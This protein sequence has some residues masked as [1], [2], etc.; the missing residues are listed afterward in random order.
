MRARTHPDN[1]NN[2]SSAADVSLFRHWLSRKRDYCT[3]HASDIITIYAGMLVVI[4][5]LYVD[6][7]FAL[8]HR[9]DGDKQTTNYDIRLAPGALRS[10]CNDSLNDVHLAEKTKPHLR[11]W[12]QLLSFSSQQ[13]TVTEL[14]SSRNVSGLAIGVMRY[15]YANVYWAVMDVYN[16]W[17]ITRFLNHTAS[18]D[19]AIVL[20]DTAPVTSLDS[21][22]QTTFSSVRRVHTLGI[23]TRFESMA[24]LFSRSYSP[25]LDRTLA[26]LPLL[27]EFRRDVLAGNGIVGNYVR[28]CKR[29]SVFFVLRRDYSRYGGNNTGSSRVMSNFV[30]RKI[31]NEHELLTSIHGSFPEFQVRAKQLDEHTMTEQLQFLAHTDVLIGMHGAAMTLSMFMP[32]GGAVIEL[33]PR[34]QRNYNWHMEAIARWSG[35]RYYSWRNRNSSQEDAASGYTTVPPDVV[36]SRVMQAYTDLC[37]GGV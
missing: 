14:T 31:R 34:Y 25:L 20:F 5:N 7:H 13:T 36:V 26:S 24:W 2:V 22:W 16:C 15:E 28:S 19:T 12:L 35:H 11:H 27:G 9:H 3:R 33:W 30:S 17:L 32:P 4:N 21:L 1:V 10:H 6:P 8:E 37:L 18:I 23:R 29:L